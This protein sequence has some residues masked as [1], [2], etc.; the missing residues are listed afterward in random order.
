MPRAG[1]A[2]YGGPLTGPKE[3]AKLVVVDV[4]QRRVIDDGSHRGFVQQPEVTIG[5][6][7][8]AVRQDEL[9]VRGIALDQVQGDPRLDALDAAHCPVSV[10][11]AEHVLDGI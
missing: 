4:F 3:L 11:I 7:A 2:G 10:Q 9:G 1:A 8:A 6:A 5:Q